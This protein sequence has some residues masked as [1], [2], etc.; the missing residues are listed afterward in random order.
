MKV[1]NLFNN[2]AVPIELVVRDTTP[3]SL[4]LLNS[5]PHRD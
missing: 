4:M 2:Q 1:F 3:E 5:N